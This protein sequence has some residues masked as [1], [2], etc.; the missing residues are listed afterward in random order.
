MADYKISEFKPKKT[1]VRVKIIEDIVKSLS[2]DEVFKTVD[3]EEWKE[4]KIAAY[5]YPFLSR[6]M[7][8][9]FQ[10][11]HPGQSSKNISRKVENAVLWEGAHNKT[12]SADKV[13]GSRHYPD[14]AVHIRGLKIAIE[15]KIGGGGGSLRGGIGQSL[16]YSMDYDFVIYLLVDSSKERRVKSNSTGKSESYLIQ[17]IWEK[18]NIKLVI[19]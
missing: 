4:K 12:I 15:L 9:I 11:L 16:I 1:A 6:G 7:E 19:V 2:S 18:Y 8:K 14:F 3:K 13:F 17:S 10:D 5:L